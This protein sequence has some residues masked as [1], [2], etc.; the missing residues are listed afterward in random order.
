[1]SGALEARRVRGPHPDPQLTLRRTRRILGPARRR[2]TTAPDG[3]P[4]RRILVPRSARQCARPSRQSRHLARDA[5]GQRDPH[6]TGRMAYGRA[7]RHL[8]RHRRFAR[9]VGA[10]RPQPAPVL[11]SEGSGR[12][13]HL[14]DRGARRFPHRRD[15]P[16]RVVQTFMLNA[17]P[18]CA[19]RCV[20][21]SIW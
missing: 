19:R 12:D 11:S 18:R 5:A 10:R 21:S 20:A 9:V 16:A 3:P 13:H 2:T 14:P 6:A 17:S 7:A 1:M 15:H 8:P 4:P